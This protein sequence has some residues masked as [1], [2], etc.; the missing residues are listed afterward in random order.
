[1]PPRETEEVRIAKAIKALDNNEFETMKDATFAFKVGYQK[2]RAR[3]LGR[4]PS[5]TRSGHN[6]LLSET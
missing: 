4:P 5:L 2:L 3:Q 6:K 1:M